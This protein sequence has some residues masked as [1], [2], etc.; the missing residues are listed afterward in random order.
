MAKALVEMAAEIV[1]AQAAH[2]KMSADDMAI[3]IGK[4]VDAMRKAR[5]IEEGTAEAAPETP[6]RK[7]SVFRNRV[8]C[9]EC[10][11][12]FKQLTNRHLSQ[13]GLDKKSYKSKYGIPRAQRLVATALTEHRRQMAEER[14]LGQQ[15]VEARR[16]RAE[17]AKAKAKPKKQPVRRTKAPAVES[18]LE[19]KG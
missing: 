6:V 13:H 5:D 2:T 11:K 9:L 7:R 8:I 4:L 16:M 10:G 1:N 12:E 3:A 18:P 19:P 15:L 17:K 14:G